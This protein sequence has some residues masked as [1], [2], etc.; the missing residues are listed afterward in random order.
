MIDLSRYFRK[1]NQLSELERKL[2]SL[3]YGDILDVDCGTGNYI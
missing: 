3:S 2:I 1:T